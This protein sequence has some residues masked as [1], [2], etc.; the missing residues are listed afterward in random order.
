MLSQKTWGKV[1]M[2][3]KRNCPSWSFPLNLCFMKLTPRLTDMYG[4]LVPNLGPYPNSSTVRAPLTEIELLHNVYCTL[5]SS[6]CMKL[7]LDV[8][9]DA[10]Q[11]QQYFCLFNHLPR[12]VP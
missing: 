2:E 1:S 10:I 8:I 6:T 9:S 12:T 5:E 4:L 11:L 7:A 3:V